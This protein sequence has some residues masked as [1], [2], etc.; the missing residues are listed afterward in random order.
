[1][2]IVN[3]FQNHWDNKIALFYKNK[4]ENIIPTIVLVL[5]CISVFF[6]LINTR[7]AREYFFFASYF[8]IFFLALDFRNINKYLKFAPILI[9][10]GIIKIIWFLYFYAGTSSMD[11]NN[12][13]VQAGKRLVLA[14]IIIAYLLKKKEFILYKREIISIT[15]WA[16]FIATS[17]IG[18]YQTL[19]W[20]DRISFINTRSTDAAYMY[21]SISLSL[22]CCI[23]TNKN[24]KKSILTGV[25]FLISM[26][27]IIQTGTRSAILV[28]PLAFIIIKLSSYEPK[29]RKYVLGI[30]VIAIVCLFSILRNDIENKI[31]QTKSELSV[32]IDSNGNSGSSL[33]TRLAMWQSGLAVFKAHPFGMSLEQ[34]YQY[35]SDYVH[36]VGRGESALLYAKIHLHDESIETMTQQGIVGLIMLWAF[37]LIN[38]FKAYTQKNILLLIT[39]FCMI[40]YGVTD[41]LL[42][43]R[44]QTIYFGIMLMIAYILQSEPSAIRIMTVD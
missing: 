37:Y 24:L 11:L 2:N 8:V 39:L 33:G 34:R 7:Y 14:S 4:K 36:Q 9:T 12:A 18:F 42:I 38:L 31:N 41:V 5:C 17:L 25:I 44:E 35:M 15:L 1:M 30:C 40:M 13:S 27:L 22:I 43:S 28:H 26:F 16:T 29:N 23:L 10:L 21:S 32:Y 20:T 6:T 19:T 3:V